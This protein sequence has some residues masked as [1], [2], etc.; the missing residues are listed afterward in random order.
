MSIKKTATGMIMGV[1]SLSS[2]KKQEAI[3]AKVKAS[4]P[5]KRP[6]QMDKPLKHKNRHILAMTKFNL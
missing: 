1:G 3:E 5:C 2:N 6:E 4:S